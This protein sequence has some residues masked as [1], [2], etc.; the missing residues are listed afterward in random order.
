MSYTE[1]LDAYMES[2]NADLDLKI[3]KDSECLEYA[4]NETYK[5]MTLTMQKPN[6]IKFN[7]GIFD[8]NFI[9]VFSFDM[10]DEIEYVL[11]IDTLYANTHV[12]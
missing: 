9:D 12:S 4:I 6:K 5:P 7:H 2:F 11:D 1:K 3:I 10:N 8:P